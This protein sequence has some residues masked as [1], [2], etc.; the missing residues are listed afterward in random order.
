MNDTAAGVLELAEVF[1]DDAVG[2]ILGVSRE[3]VGRHRRNLVAAGLL[4]ATERGRGINLIGRNVKAATAAANAAAFRLADRLHPGRQAR[5]RTGWEPARETVVERLD[6][7]GASA[8]EALC[9]VHCA[10]R[11]LEAMAR[12]RKGWKPA[13]VPPVVELVN[14]A[15][16]PV[17]ALDQTIAAISNRVTVAAARLDVDNMTPGDLVTLSAAMNHAAQAMA[18]VAAAR[19]VGVPKAGA[20]GP[21]VTPPAIGEQV[22]TAQRFLRDAA[23]L[24]QT[25]EDP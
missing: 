25:T 7:E 22:A 5:R 23:A 19:T 2:E 13:V 17:E 1:S 12:K 6:V 16:D 3:G 18:R 11:T 8:A 9:F 4:E 20:A 15:Q 10:G 14:P 21:G 24:R